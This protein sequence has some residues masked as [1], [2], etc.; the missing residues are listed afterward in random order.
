[1]SEKME[2][3]DFTEPLTE[4]GKRVL[5]FYVEDYSNYYDEQTIMFINHIVNTV[6]FIHR[7]VL[8]IF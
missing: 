3:K 1:M 4:P 8:D 7:N 2:Y 5:K 6:D